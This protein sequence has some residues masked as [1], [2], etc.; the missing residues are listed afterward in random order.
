MALR[1]LVAA[2]RRLGQDF[3]KSYGR[4]FPAGRLSKNGMNALT[5]HASVTRAIGECGYK[6]GAN[7]V[8]VT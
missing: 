2:G 8:M 6:K 4:R 1:G 3:N 7:L 5:C